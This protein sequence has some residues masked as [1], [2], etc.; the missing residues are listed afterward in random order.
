MQAELKSVS[1]L[2][3]TLMKKMLTFKLKINLQMVFSQDIGK[4]HHNVLQK[5]ESWMSQRKD[6]RAGRQN[7]PV[8]VPVPPLRRNQPTSMA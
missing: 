7:T 5:V 2:T 1:F 4:N 3:L 8:L 6:H